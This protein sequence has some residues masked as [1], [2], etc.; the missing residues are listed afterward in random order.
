M[1]NKLRFTLNRINEKLWV[2][3]LIA[4]ALSIGVALLAKAVDGSQLDALF[5]VVSIESAE[6]LLSILAASMLVIATFSVAS[7]ISAYS[8]ASSTA[9]P[10]SFALIIADD[11][12][13]NALAAFIGSFIFSV[14]ALIGL[15]NGF[16]S[17]SGR[18]VLFAVTLLV[19][20]LVIVTFLRW[21]NRI[22]RLG[23]LEATIEKV[24]G[25][26]LESLQRRVENPHL[27]GC[28]VSE[29][30]GPATGVYAENIGYVQQVDIAALQSAAESQ[31]AR[32][33]VA[34]L[35][36]SFVTPGRPI[37]WLKSEA[38]EELVP[39]A[40]EK[41]FTIGKKRTFD[42]DPRFGLIVL[43]EIACRAL[44]PGIN[45]PGTAISVIGSMVRALSIWGSAGG[46]AAAT[47]EPQFD[48]VEVPA[49]ALEDLYDDAF[50][51][52]ARDAAGSF[53]VVIRLL[54]AYESLIQIADQ[55]TRVKIEAHAQVAFERAEAALEFSTDLSKVR[56]VFSQL[57]AATAAN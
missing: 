43:S 3:P 18:F 54:K 25:A 29:P 39:E 9:T 28:P 35:P 1:I 10:R 52:I 48:R 56:G 5:P 53:E 51:T 8:A 31:A 4:C 33:E 55:D 13:Q 26:A 57:K 6:K 42:D 46:S 49:L 36:G 45:D 37:A 47:V 11:V 23:R 27:G 7:M 30:R 50:S 15:L 20:A 21:V 14:V 24:E 32:I 19:F 44:S 2:R 38:G 40:F 16:Y 41:A 22:A 34:A 17:N 12:S